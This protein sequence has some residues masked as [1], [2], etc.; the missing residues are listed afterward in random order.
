MRKPVLLGIVFL[1]I[2]L[3][4]IIYSSRSLAAYRVEVCMDFNGH[5]SCRTVRGATEESALRSAINN[6]CA[7]IASGVTDSIA[8][9]HTT[10]KSV[11][12]LK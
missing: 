2:V 7:E 8:C 10:P 12:W 6:A 5:S 1:A 3:A 9:E 4:V 11:T